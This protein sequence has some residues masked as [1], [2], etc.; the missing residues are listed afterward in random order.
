M[1]FVIGV[2]KRVDYV[3]HYFNSCFAYV[4]KIAEDELYLISY[5]ILYSI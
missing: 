1:K 4:W 2:E 3:Q 5:N